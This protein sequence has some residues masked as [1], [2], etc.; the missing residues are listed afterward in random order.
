MSVTSSGAAIE[1]TAKSVR[2]SANPGSDV[3]RCHTSGLRDLSMA[4][5]GHA[6]ELLAPRWPLS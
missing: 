3:V 6:E 2:F 4:A 5:K 1:R